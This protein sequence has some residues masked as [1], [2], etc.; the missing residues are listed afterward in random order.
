MPTT[1]GTPIVTSEWPYSPSRYVAT[2]ITC[3]LSLTTDSTIAEIAFPGA[4]T[5]APFSSMTFAAT[6]FVFWTSSSNFSFGRNDDNGI[7]ETEEN[8]GKGNMFSPCSPIT[9]AL[10]ES[11]EC[12]VASWIN[13]LNLDK[14]S[15]PPIPNTLLLSNPDTL[16]VMYAIGSNGLVTGIIIES[17][18][19]FFTFSTTLFTIDAL[20]F[21]RSIRVIPGFLP[22]PATTTTILE[23]FISSKL[24]EPFTS[25]SIPCSE[26]IWLISIASPW[27]SPSAT[28]SN[29]IWSSN[30]F[31][32]ENNAASPP[33]LPEP[34]IVIIKIAVNFQ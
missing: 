22:E 26:S 18:A 9:S 28:S 33:T 5:V 34:I 27:G 1:A 12:P 7:P 20:I 15:I 21:K 24:L 10:I 23:P 16:Y 13:C 3:F 4:C 11:R 6:C 2:G 25:T 31:S 29:K 32:A 17:S 19:Y 30:R 14:S 8:L